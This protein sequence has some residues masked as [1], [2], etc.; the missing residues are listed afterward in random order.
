MITQ[1]L[2]ALADAPYR[3]FTA[4]LI[5][6]VDKARIIG[7]RTPAMRTL[8]K[9]LLKNESEKAMAFLEELPHYYYEENNLHAFIIAELKD[10]EQVMKYTERFLPYIDNWATCDTFAPKIFLKYPEETLVY[11]Q[12]W[13]ASTDTYTVRYGIGI[14]LSNYLDAHF[15]PVHLQWV[16]AIK[17]SEYYINMMIAWYLATALA[18]QYEATLSY[19][20]AKTLTPFVQNKSIQKARE[21]KRITPEIKEYLLTLKVQK[22]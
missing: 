9:E 18:K 21:S 15:S 20:Q 3:N 16:T 2:I 22:S 5:P 13:L 11:V 6:T 4:G 12:K 8:A 19:L 10:F 17:S 1:K 14:L 7:V